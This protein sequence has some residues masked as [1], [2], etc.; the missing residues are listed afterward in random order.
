MQTTRKESQVDNPMVHEME[1]I[2]R[3]LQRE[4]RFG[5]W[6]LE[7]ALGN[8]KEAATNYFGQVLGCG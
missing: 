1:T 8:G 2:A 7:L 4:L 3:V 6:G 5:V